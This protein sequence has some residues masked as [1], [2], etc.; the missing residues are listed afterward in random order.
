MVRRADI[1]R[2][3]LERAD[4]PLTS[5]EIGQQLGL[6]G[7]QVSAVLDKAEWAEVVGMGPAPKGRQVKLWKVKEESCRN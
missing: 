5:L 2:P 1:I 3:I 4:R 6:G 7:G